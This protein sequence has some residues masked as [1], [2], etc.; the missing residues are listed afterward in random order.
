MVL[1]RVLQKYISKKKI[2]FQRMGH[3]RDLLAYKYKNLLL[4][5]VELEQLFTFFL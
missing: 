4:Q 2:L 5:L 3:F 1:K